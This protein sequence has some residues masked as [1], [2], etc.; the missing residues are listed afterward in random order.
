M[1]NIFN[2]HTVQFNNGKYG[3]RK[4]TLKGWLY[5]MNKHY[6]GFSIL[7]PWTQSSLMFNTKEEIQDRLEKVQKYIANVVKVVN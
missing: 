1:K 5:L 6:P 7:T 4:L 2:W 3:C